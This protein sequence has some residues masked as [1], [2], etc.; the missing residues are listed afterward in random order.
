MECQN[1]SLVLSEWT[2]LASATKHENWGEPG[3]MHLAVVARTI[4]GGAASKSVWVVP[5]PSVLVWPSAE[6]D[7]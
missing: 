3:N 2:E 5:Y 6:A 4:H 7:P 1:F